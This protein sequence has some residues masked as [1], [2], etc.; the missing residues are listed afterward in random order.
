MVAAAVARGTAVAEGVMAESSGPSSDGVGD[1][2]TASAGAGEGKSTVAGVGSGK[3]SLPQA[4][5][6]ASA[7]APAISSANT[8]L[9]LP[10]SA[11]NGIDLGIPKYATVCG[12]SGIM[13][14]IIRPGRETACT[15]VFG[16]SYDV[17]RL[18]RTHPP[19]CT[20]VECTQRRNRGGRRGGGGGPGRRRFGCLPLL[21]A[22]SAV[23]AF[24]AVL[25]ASL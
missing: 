21:M 18:R 10:R 23:V 5:I 11:M 1:P 17:N 19:A 22:L 2:V 8:N 6:A 12:A 13:L 9:R 3:G 15:R 20:C 4:V 16:M 24:G 25:A 7:N 14:Q